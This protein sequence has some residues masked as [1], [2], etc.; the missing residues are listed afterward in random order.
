MIW[1]IIP[2]R[3]RKAGRV[4]CGGA[5]DTHSATCHDGVTPSK[6]KKFL[7]FPRSIKNELYFWLTIKMENLLIYEITKDQEIHGVLRRT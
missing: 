4:W 6:T 1:L 5:R 3:F 2:L 7:K